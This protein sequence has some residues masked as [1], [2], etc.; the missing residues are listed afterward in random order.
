MGKG[1]AFMNLTKLLE[2]FEE[3]PAYQQLLA[4]LPGRALELPRS[5]KPPLL[6]R[7]FED[8]SR[9]VLFITGRV[10]GVPLW[11][12]TLENWLPA[13]TELHRFP[14]PTP[15]PY[16]RGPWSQPSRMGRLAVLT[17]LMAGQHPSLPAASHHPFLITS[18][19]ALLQ[20][21]LPRQR[22]LA[23]LRLLRVGQSLELEKTLRSWEEI[24]YEWR[25]VVEAAGQ[26]SQRGGIIDLFPAGATYPVR[27]ELFGDEIETM[28]YFNPASQRSS[29]I[30][31]NQIDQLLIPPGREAMPGRAKD[32]GHI[33]TDTA[34]PKEDDLPAWQDDIGPLRSGQPFAN[35]EFYLPL[36]YQ[37][38]AGLLH[39]LPANS[40]I[41]IDDWPELEIATHELFQHASQIASDQEKLPPDYPNP[42]FTWEQFQGDL[43]NRQLLILGEGPQGRQGTP[44][45]LTQSFQPGP[46]YGGQMR[47]LLTQLRQAQLDKERTVIVSSQAQRLAE[48]W[49]AES[50]AVLPP[51][52]IETNP[53][54]L[55]PGEIIF[56]Q[57]GLLE[58]FVLERPSDNKI[59]LNLLTDAEIFGWRRPAPRRWQP[60]RPVSPETPFADIKIGDYVVHIEFGVGRF[61][62]LVVRYV[63]GTEREYLQLEYANGD[64]LYVPAH[65][66]DRLSKWVGNDDFSPTTHRLGDKGWKAAKQQAQQDIA[67]LADELLDLYATREN[68]AGHAFAKD[69]EW[70]AEME[71]AFAYQE[72]EDQLRAI[73]EVKTDMEKSQPMDRLICGDVGYGKTEVALRAAF[74]A[75][76]DSKQVALLVPTTVLAQQH[77]TN[78][79]ERLRAFPIKVEMLSRFRTAGQQEEIVKRLRNGQ[80]DIVIGTHRLLS[81][82][83]S[84]KDLGLVIIDEEQRFGVAHKERLKQLRTEVDVLTMTA[85]PIPRTLYMGMSGVRD[86]SLI[87][88]APAE[89]LPVQTYVGEWDES[90]LKR[91]ILRELDRGGQIFFVHNRVQ[92]IEIVAAQLRRL[93]PEARLGI[94][95]G[96]MSER[97]LEQVM[98]QFVDGQIDIL[99][100]TSIIESG[101][102]IP[103]AN[104]LIVD[105][106][107]LMG[108]A[109]LYQLR[110]RVGRGIRRA[111]GY[112]FHAPWRSLTPEAQA[113]LDTIAETT[114]LGAG[115][116]ISMRDLE[117]RGAGELLGGK[118]SGHIATIGFDLYARL[119]TQAVKQR[120]AARNGES[121]SL[122][123][124]EPTL[125]DLPLAAY[126]PIDYIPDP[127][128]RLRL[129]RRMAGL[130][131]LAEIDEM[132]I[133]LADRFGPIPDPV[134]NLLYQLRV[135][136]LAA[137]AGITTIAVESNQIRLKIPALENMPRF[138]LQRYLG[139]TA[140]VS[141]SAIWLGR[142]LA[143]N[144]WKVALVQLLE[145]VKNFNPVSAS[146]EMEGVPA[147]NT[148]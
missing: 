26:F 71:A 68:I 38:P 94:G 24:G 138:H 33:L 40:L 45:L 130:E 23:A 59:L 126:V 32:L 82:D 13:G 81:D 22:F 73:H 1:K 2:F 76:M 123:L 62:G 41:I 103:N 90:L 89:R 125:I 56:V 34:P 78:F 121:L 104:T 84:F 67:A 98:A 18:A 29:D 113:R 145:K 77:F 92:T 60:S 132:A 83:V 11:V 69:G 21:T 119:L 30:A 131:S 44:P 17:R 12:Q 25:S 142:E 110:G 55:R 79:S 96:Q 109:Q 137:P 58:G 16:D 97:E 100:S 86:I 47:P 53:V 144:E 70:Q 129:Y 57:G 51:P 148:P 141:K 93:V 43:A 112:F 39:Y 99:I 140:R 106:P 14:E 111:Y 48:L 27:I 139:A 147:G 85:T 49:Q 146:E 9:P 95:H 105:R 88:T 117:I 72:T 128:L 133:E 120:K 124:P 101:L 63:G 74:K 87:D 143:T 4:N 5:A 136:V 91:A 37:R 108:L 116:T 66:A 80:V 7:L 122:E 31:N 135:K 102:D 64:I 3:L 6:A 127:A 15:L 36:I 61:V 114:E 28:R 10:D 42:L 35:I 107:E 50:S 8:L 20:K 19:R 134:D 118:Q 52:T 75:V 65:H 46:R 115:Y 54:M